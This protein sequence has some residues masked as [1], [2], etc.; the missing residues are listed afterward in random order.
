MSVTIHSVN[1]DTLALAGS[2]VNT[3]NINTILLTIW[4][5]D[6]G[7]VYVKRHNIKLYIVH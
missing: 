5:N 4:K 7:I 6:S 3:N 2:F 1:Y